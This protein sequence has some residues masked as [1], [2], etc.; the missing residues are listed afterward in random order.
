MVPS[1]SAQNLECIKIGKDFM[2]SHDY[3]KN[4]FT[5]EEIKEGLAVPVQK[6]CDNCHN[7]RPRR[8]RDDEVSATA[9]KV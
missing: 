7:E 3:I 2:F 9:T 4:D 1:L 5:E 6:F 8:Y